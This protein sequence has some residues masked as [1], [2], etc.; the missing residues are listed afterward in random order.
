MFMGMMN[1]D[2]SGDSTSITPVAVHGGTTFTSITSRGRD[3]DEQTTCALDSQ[4]AAWCWSS[5]HAFPQ[6]LAGGYTFSS[7]VAGTT[8]T[9][10]LAVTDSTGANITGTAL[11]WGKSTGSLPVPEG[12]VLCFGP[13]LD[14]R[15][16]ECIA[17]TNG[18]HPW[19]RPRAALNANQLQVA[20]PW[21]TDP[22]LLERGQSR[23]RLLCKEFLHSLNSP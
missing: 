21:A 16:S 5:F 6:Q 10:G 3:G 7:L 2:Y 11:C 22:D 20:A 17:Q 19:P 23:H 14:S 18:S 15:E 4:G 1:G 8:M 12:H 9:C 13:D